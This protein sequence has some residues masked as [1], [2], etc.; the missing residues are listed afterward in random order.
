MESGLQP[1]LL[2][3]VSKTFSCRSPITY[4][5]SLTMKVVN[6]GHLIN[7]DHGQVDTSSGTTFGST[8]IYTCD[9]GYSLSGSQTSTCGAD[10]MWI[11][12]KP[13]CEG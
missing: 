7:P 6:C 8:A 1:D 3:L 5:I 2:V 10:G 12:S 11:P 13:L 9:T 4:L